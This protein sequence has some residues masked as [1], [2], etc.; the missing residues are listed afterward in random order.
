MEDPVSNEQ[1]KA[2]YDAACKR[3]LSEKGIVAQ[4]LKT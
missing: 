1:L 2:L 3:V 4:I